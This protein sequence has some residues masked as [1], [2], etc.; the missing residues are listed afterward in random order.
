MGKLLGT[1][2][3]WNPEELEKIHQ[4]SLDMLESV[5]VRVDSDDVLSILAGSDARIDRDRKIVK[6]P[7]AMVQERMR[8][9]PGCWDR[10]SGSSDRVLGER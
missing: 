7:A 9:A 2:D 3:P 5:G 10:V 1:L 8:N 6:F 4:A